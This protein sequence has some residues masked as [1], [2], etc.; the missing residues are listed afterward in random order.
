MK[1]IYCTCDV[2]MLEIL[3]RLLEEQHAEEFQV[4]DR[5]IARNRKGEPRLDTPVWPGYN[6]VVMVPADE[7]KFAGLS[8]AILNL[9][10]EMKSENEQITIYSWDLQE[11]TF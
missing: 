6:A 7:K 1:M 11:T 4:F 5:V 8:E 2:S 9:N 10:R 3:L